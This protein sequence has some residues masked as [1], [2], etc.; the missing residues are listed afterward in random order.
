MDNK[1]N[2]HLQAL[3]E[4]V[5]SLHCLQEIKQKGILH[6]SICISSISPER[7]WGLG[8]VVVFGQMLGS[9]PDN[10]IAQWTQIGFS[11]VLLD[12]ISFLI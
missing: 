5:L 7:N 1:L 3:R 11:M 8:L 4:I 12:L 6:F 2:A 10:F 9:F